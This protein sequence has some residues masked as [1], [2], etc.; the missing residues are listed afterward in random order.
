MVRHQVRRF[1]NFSNRY[2][3]R[4]LF[5]I[6]GVVSV[7]FAGL[8]VYLLIDYPTTT[9]R[10]FTKEELQLAYVRILHDQKVNVAQ[11]TNRLTP[12]QSVLAVLADARSYA[13]LVSRTVV[14]AKNIH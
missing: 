7:F 11:N 3:R 9:K 12:W 8:F 14:Q 13:F 1:Q 4:W 6:E 2:H 5:L 10:F